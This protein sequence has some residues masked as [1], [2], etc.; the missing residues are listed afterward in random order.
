M[1]IEIDSNSGFCFGV[2]KA[3]EIAEKELEH[4]KTLYC[5][6]DIVH[7]DA[8][9]KRLENKGLVTINHDEFKLLKNVKVLLR[10]HGEPPATYETAKRNNIELIDA[11]CP[12]VLNLQ[13]KIDKAYHN[14]E[15]IEG[16]IVIFGK[17]GHAEVIGLLGHTDNKGI[18]VSDINDLKK[19]DFSKP[20]SIFSQTTKSQTSYHEIINEIKNRLKSNQENGAIQFIANDSTCRAVSNRDVY[21]KEFAK[22]H[23]IIIFVSGK[24]SSNGKVL[25]QVCKNENE[26]TYFVSEPEELQNEWFKPNDSVGICGATSTPE[27]LM[28]KIRDQIKTFEN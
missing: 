13:K 4:E 7:N 24:K 12:I 25:Y 10:A 3:I 23:N 17:E 18:V 8:E 21:L 11:S 20:I 19:I 28:E 26:R 5:L 15:E 2:V 1:K 16:Q 14:F 22:K 6:G 9:V 27:W